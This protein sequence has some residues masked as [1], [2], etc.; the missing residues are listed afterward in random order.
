MPVRLR[1]ISH[2]L[3]VPFVSHVKARSC[4]EVTTDEADGVTHTYIRP[5]AKQQAQADDAQVAN[6]T[7]FVSDDSVTS[8][9]ERSFPSGRHYGFLAQEVIIT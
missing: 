3:N 4:P 7:L 2:S 5:T 1:R 8:T 9:L 6:E